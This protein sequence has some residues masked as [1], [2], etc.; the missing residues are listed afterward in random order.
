M[1]RLPHQYVRILDIFELKKVNEI[2]EEAALRGYT[3]KNI[4]TSSKEYGMENFF[5]LFERVE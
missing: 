5:I 4:T 3:V 2:I 1:A